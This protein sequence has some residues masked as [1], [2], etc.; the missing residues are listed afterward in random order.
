MDR[1]RKI[2]EPRRVGIRVLAG[3]LL[4]VLVGDEHRFERGWLH[5]EHPRERSGARLQNRVHLRGGLLHPR[6]VDDRDHAGQAFVAWQG[7]WVSHEHR[8]YGATV[9]T[10]VAPSMPAVYTFTA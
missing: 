1:T 9:E 10:R 6:R 5:D 4:P 2:W 7:N 8:C 3:R